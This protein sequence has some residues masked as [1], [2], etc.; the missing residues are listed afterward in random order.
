[1]SKQND[2]VARTAK[3]A[4]QEKKSLR[5]LSEAEMRT[6]AGGSCQWS[7]NIEKMKNGVRA[8]PKTLPTF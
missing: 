6:V 4:N 7:P 3:L 8:L 5:T 2:K 1:M